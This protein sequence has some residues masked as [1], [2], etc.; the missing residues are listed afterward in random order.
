MRVDRTGFFLFRTRGSDL[1]GAGFVDQVNT[2]FSTAR[3]QCFLLPFLTLPMDL[4]LP[5]PVPLYTHHSR[6]RSG[7]GQYYGVRR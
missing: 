7:S 3:V 5:V 2:R 6:R 4:M 1:F